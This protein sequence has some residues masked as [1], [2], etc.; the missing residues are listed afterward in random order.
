MGLLD[1]LKKSPRDVAKDEIEEVPWHMLNKMDQLDTIV[2]ES[3]EKPVAIFKHS[4]R[5]GISRMVLKQFEKAYE[6]SDS[7]AK[8]YYLDLLQNRDISSEI[9]ARFEVY[10]ESPQLLVIKDGKAVDHA[11]HHS[12]S[13]NQILKFI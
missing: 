5:C 1:F 10:H 3:K 4:T 11:S 13:P 6:L 2:E 8:L 12:I 7:E 9:A